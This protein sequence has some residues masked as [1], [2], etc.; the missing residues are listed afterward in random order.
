MLVFDLTL[1][2][3]FLYE[4]ANRLCLKSNL[5][6]ESHCSICF[7]ISN[8]FGHFL[9]HDNYDCYFMNKQFNT[10]SFFSVPLFER[11]CTFFSNAKDFLLINVLL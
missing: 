3:F 11:V 4:L 5:Y 6:F 1:T 9:F 8:L 7:V 10:K 2:I